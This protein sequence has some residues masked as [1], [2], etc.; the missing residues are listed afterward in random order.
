M[1]N[2][3]SSRYGLAGY[4]FGGFILFSPLLSAADPKPSDLQSKLE[5]LERRLQQL[6]QQHSDPVPTPSARP[7][8]QDDLRELRRQLD[9][10][11]EEVEKVRSG[12]PALEITPE[13]AQAL[14]LG[15]SAASVY[16][17]QRG[18]SVAGYGEMLYQNF[19]GHN[20]E[21]Q[22]VNKGTQ[23]DFLRSILYAGYRFND[24]FLFNSEIEFEHASTSIAGS[25]SV[26]FA[27]LDYVASDHLTLRGGLLLVPMGL[28]N[29]FHEPNVFLGAR[30]PQTER[31]IIPSTWRENGFGVVGSYGPIQYR[32][33]GINGLNGSKFGSNGLR[34][35]RQKGS[36]AKA[37]DLAFVGRVDVTPTAGVLVGGSLYRGGSDQGQFQVENRELNV[38][39]TIGE[40]HAQ[41]RAR[42]FDLRGL[43]AHASLEDVVALN[44]VL[45]LQGNQSVGQTLQGGYLQFGYDV[46]SSFRQDVALTPYYRF[47]KLDTQKKVP[48]LFWKNPARDRVFHTVGLEFRP[49]YGIVVKTDYEWI[50]NEADTGLSQFNLALG[51]AF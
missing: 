49:I 24:K 8:V 33:Y 48:A 27:Y 45:S 17:K 18:V 28:V 44:Q 34:G 14:G 42:G 4:L 7:S 35:G 20:Q 43:Y 2:R 15:P 37:S 51:Y 50:Q 41:V 26:E 47:E 6:E 23:L 16:R 30:R 11:A 38:D 3:L 40:V 31:R 12:E 10:L 25:A 22:P 9:I 21:G 39:T 32:A 19:A 5:E 46:L 36:S 1:K 29:E 13:A